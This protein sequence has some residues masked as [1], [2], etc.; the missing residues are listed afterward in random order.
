VA[1]CSLGRPTPQP[2]PASKDSASLLAPDGRMEFLGGQRLWIMLGL[3]ALTM[4]IIAFLPRFTRAVPSSLA[5]ILVNPAKVSL[6]GPSFSTQESIESS[7]SDSIR[8][9]TSAISSASGRSVTR[10]WSR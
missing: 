8:P 4:A 1:I 9:N 7:R 3:V 6:T 10:K 2:C 5:A